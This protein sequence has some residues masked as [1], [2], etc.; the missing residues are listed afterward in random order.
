[1]NHECT[2]TTK[3]HEYQLIAKSTTNFS[4]FTE[5]K[6][7]SKSVTLKDFLNYVTPMIQNSN[8]L[9]EDLRLLYDILAA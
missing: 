4:E 5:H 7:P 6:N 3:I 8:H 1:M 9:L 2:R